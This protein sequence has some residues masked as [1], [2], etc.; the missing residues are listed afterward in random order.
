MSV[1]TV[2]NENFEA[3]VLKNEKTVLLDFWAEWCGPCRMFSPIIDQLS[4]KNESITVGKI[5]VDEQGELAQKFGIVSIPTVV[6]MK[7]GEIVAKSTGFKPL[8]ELEEL[9]ENL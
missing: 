3:E 1:I 6:I 7:N 9:I 8:Q 4:E 5:N 2:T